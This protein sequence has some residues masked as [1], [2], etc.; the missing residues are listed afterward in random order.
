MLR[1][2]QAPLVKLLTPKGEDAPAWRVD[3]VGGGVR[4]QTLAL[5]TGAQVTYAVFDG[6]LV[7][8][9]GPDAIRRI[10]DAK[11]SLT[12]DEAF[13]KVESR[14]ENPTSLGFLDFSQLLELGE[15]TGLN[16]SRAYQ[17]ARDDLHRVKSV[18]ISSHSGEGETTAEILLSIP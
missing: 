3:D 5:P 6:H 16:D 15:Q 10:K 12:D 11:G 14:P 7:V 4:A 17:L 8:G 18:G 9:T 13:E 1:R 2:L